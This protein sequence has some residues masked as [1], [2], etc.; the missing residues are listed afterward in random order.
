MIYEADI[1]KL[2]KKRK[3][4]NI[5][6][7]F[8]TFFYKDHTKF[9]G[10]HTKNKVQVWNSTPSISLFYPVY[11]L[12]FNNN[13]ILTKVVIERNP[14]TKVIDKI[15]LIIIASLIVFQLYFSELRPAIALIIVVSIMYFLYIFIIK[16]IIKNE[17]EI[18][19]KEFNKEL[20]KLDNSISPNTIITNEVIE[21][22]W[23]T[24]KIFSRILI[25][26]FCFFIIYLS[27]TEF[28]PKGNVKFIY[29]LLIPL[30]F[31]I[32]DIL[33]AIKSLKK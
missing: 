23:T 33:I 18:L 26:L 6:N 27:L 32:S 15:I 2:I 8:L 13:E 25:Y 14:L 17:N 24:S 19:I 5:K 11:I 3:V 1:K 9:I 10:Y 16:K 12:F 28:L 30:A 7:H 31:I 4:N 22:E 29:G 21:S 20:F